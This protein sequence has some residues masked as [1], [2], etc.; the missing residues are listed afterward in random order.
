MSTTRLVSFGFLIAATFSILAAGGCGN[1]ERGSS[2]GSAPVTTQIGGGTDPD[3]AE[4]AI[5][6]GDIIQLDGGRLYAMSKSGTVSIVDVSAPGRLTLLGQT[7]SRGV[8]FEMYRRGDFLITMADGA[9]APDGSLTTT[10]TTTTTGTATD[11]G[12]GAGALVTVLDVHD[13]AQITESATLRVP[14]ELADSRVVGDVLYLA[15]YENAACYGCGPEPRTMVTTFDIADADAIELVE[16]V[17]FQSNAPDGYNLP[18]GANWK[19]SIF[20]TTERLYIG[21]HADID[22][23]GT[24]TADEGIIDVLDITDP[25][26]RLKVGS[27]LLV[28]GAILS[29]W[30]LDERD[31]V[32]RVISQKGAGRTGNGLAAPEVDTFSV[33]SATSFAPLGHTTLRLPRQEGL[34]TVRFDASRAYAITYNQTDPMFVIDLH[35]PTAPAQRGALSMPGFMYHLEPHGDRVIGLGIDRNDPGGS[36]NVSL[37]DVSDADRPRMLARA[38]FATPYLSEDYA[39]LDSEIA[40]DQDRIQKAFRVFP[41]GVV[42]V[43]FSAPQPYYASDQSC[44]N[45]G[46]GVQLVQWQSDTLAK[47]A[48]LPLPGNPRRAFELGGQ[49]IAVSDS[50]VRAFGLENPDV[51]HQTADVVIGTCVPDTDPGYYGGGGGPVVGGGDRVGDGYPRACSAAPGRTSGWAPVALALAFLAVRSTRARSALAR[52]VRAWRRRARRTSP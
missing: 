41:D 51:A 37:F 38:P 5:A 8:P 14:G 34:R 4:R 1:A 42:V 19:R 43:P 16:Q 44:A 52:A 9:V 30:Q 27:R 20:V 36:L 45:T 35:D 7:I 23:N 24:G 31:G 33:A 40:E 48:L 39:I 46:G 17:S 13:P 25:T 50:N 11:A 32:L 15:T 47:G 28:A 10:T 22:P 21:G 3:G 2:G 29:R 49:M 12:A 6:E 26:G 18:W